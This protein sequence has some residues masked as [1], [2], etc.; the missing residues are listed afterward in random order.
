[1]PSR[2]AVSRSIDHAG[3]QPVV[4]LIAGHVAQLRQASRAS[5][6]SLR[7][8]LA[9]FLGVGI[10]QAVLILR[11]ADAGFDRQVL[12]R[13]HE[14]RDALDLGQRRLQAANHLA[15]RRSCALPAA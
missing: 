10:F 8:P 11:A 4:L 1:M 6:T 15:G 13:L 9:Q 2:E 12:H 7:H 14:Q 5:P 3:L